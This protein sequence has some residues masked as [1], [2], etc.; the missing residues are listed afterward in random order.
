MAAYAQR[1]ADRVARPAAESS[2]GLAVHDDLNARSAVTQA[3]ATAAR[4]NAR[5]ET[6]QR[7]PSR[8]D[9]LPDPLRTNME[10]MSGIA[11]DDVRVHRNS[12]RPAQMQAHAYAQG[13]DIHLGPGQ[14]KHLPHEAWHVVQQKQGRVRATGHV[15][16]GV[17]MND[18]PSL[19]MEADQKGAS[20]ATL[21]AAASG[22][23]STRLGDA[24][25]QAVWIKDKKI[26]QRWYWHQ[27][28]AG[29]TWHS[30]GNDYWF[31]VVSAEGQ[32][33]QEYAGEQNK[34]PHAE[35]KSLGAEEIEDDI[36]T[37]SEDEL[38][39]R[40]PGFRLTNKRTKNDL[41]EFDRIRLVKKKIYED[42]TA[43]FDQG[44]VPE[45]H[46]K[47]RE[48]LISNFVGK[49]IGTGITNKLNSI[50][51]DLADLGVR[52]HEK[53]NMNENELLSWI[54]SVAK[55]KILLAGEGED[56]REALTHKIL[57]LRQQFPNWTITAK[58]GDPTATEDSDRMHK[59]S[60]L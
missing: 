1:E 14:E 58:L 17:A 8:S 23:V 19:E 12:D 20:A 4:L 10:A 49:Q 48:Q 52:E 42:K 29:V 37:D 25:L 35:W 7:K 3:K 40:V 15:R 50:A 11:L 53:L 38:E 60:V 56:L 21:Q 59:K 22:P 18:D 32:E 44:K 39:P 55:I 54:K 5:A 2:P 51:V 36:F 6:V 26:A 31:E 27:P 46:R 24:V 33:L 28:I 34:R 57:E 47:S 16:G 9:G 30:D 41:A 13:T 43:K 45:R